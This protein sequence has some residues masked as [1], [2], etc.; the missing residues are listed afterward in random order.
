MPGLRSVGAGK[1]GLVS[2]AM[3]MQNQELLSQMIPE[4]R[5]AVQGRKK[6]GS[7]VAKTAVDV[8]FQKGAQSQYSQ[9]SKRKDT[10]ASQKEQAVL[11]SQKN[12]LREPEISDQTKANENP[13][14]SQN[15]IQ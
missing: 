4:L 13:T 15:S 3:I 10:E 8:Y 12:S 7:K 1:P 2:Q 14:K 5:N 9:P 11:S 6:S